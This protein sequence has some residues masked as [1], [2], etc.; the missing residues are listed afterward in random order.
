MNVGIILSL[1][2]G[3]VYRELC[4]AAFI[5]TKL[6]LTPWNSQRE[7]RGPLSAIPEWLLERG[8]SI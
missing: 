8:A 2:C 7:I 4:P 3:N 6:Y 5:P 1:P